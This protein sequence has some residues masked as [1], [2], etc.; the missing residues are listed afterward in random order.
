MD[1]TYPFSFVLLATMADTAMAQ[2]FGPV[3]G[4]PHE[5]VFGVANAGAVQVGFGASGPPRFLYQD[6]VRLTESSELDDRFGAAATYGD[7]NGDGLIDLAIGAPGESLGA[8]TSAGAVTVIYGEPD[9]SHPS[10]VRWDDEDLLL[11]LD[12][13][14]NV[15]PR[16]GDV[17]G[18]AL[19]ASDFDHDG[20]SDLAIGVPGLDRRGQ[21]DSGA[22]VVVYGR[23]STGFDAPQVWDQDSPD[24]PDAAES[25]DRFGEVLAA[26][27]V[28]S[29]AIF[30]P[31]YSFGGFDGPNYLAIGVPHEDIDGF[32]DAG[33]VFLMRGGSYGL[34]ADARTH[35]WAQGRHGIS[36]APETHD[37]F[38]F[39][40]A[41]F[42]ARSAFT[43]SCS[44]LMIG[45]PFEDVNGMVDAGAVH[46]IFSAQ[47]ER[48]GLVTVDDYFLH[49]DAVVE[50]HSSYGLIEMPDQCEPNDQFG[51][52]VVAGVTSYTHTSWEGLDAKAAI[53]VPGEDLSADDQGAV[54]LFRQWARSDS[55]GEV[56]TSRL[57]PTTFLTQ[58]TST[59][60]DGAESGDHYG[61]SL[62]LD[63]FYPDLVIGVAGEDIGLTPDAG[64][65]EILDGLTVAS[66]WHQAMSGSPDPAEPYDGFGLFM[67]P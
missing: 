37:Q 64:A 47:P 35:F 36:D 67:T 10:G 14:L 20:Y 40:L 34:T 22:V 17:F 30:L 59:D 33:A 15:P 12:S 9:P 18:T 52:S 65:L 54:Q 46:I 25:F 4:I 31:Y 57:I 29:P 43:G 61:T 28:F 66:W 32:E 51:Y 6:G 16:P 1:P 55:D 63:I 45:V 2:A 49:Q 3:I 21:I 48:N 62:W 11:T 60:P 42:E 58:T 7:F 26:P 56:Y 53:G 27:N 19:A 41:V 5:D 13:L 50:T 39:S 24:M 44:A 23:S 38:G 8:A